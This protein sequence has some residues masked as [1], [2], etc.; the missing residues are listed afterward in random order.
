[1]RASRLLFV[2]S[3]SCGLLLGQAIGVE[4][5]DLGASQSLG[6]CHDDCFTCSSFLT[7]ASC[8]N[9][10]NEAK[11]VYGIFPTSCVTVLTKNCHE[12]LA[13]CYRD[14]YCVWVNGP[15]ACQNSTAE[16]NNPWVKKKMKTTDFC[17]GAGGG[18]PE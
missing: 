9:P 12:P 4:C 7:E 17:G 16:N 14:T 3:A 1:M 18:D 2:A 5:D 15:G 11:E 13:D 10:N 8:E 6:V